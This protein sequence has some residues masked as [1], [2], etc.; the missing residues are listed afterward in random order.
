[1]GDERASKE[2]LLRKI[3]FFSKLEQRDLKRLAKGSVTRRF[4]DGEVIV[5]EGQE[6]L[7]LYFILSGKVHVVR[8]R[9]ERDYVLATLEPEEFFGELSLLDGRPRS[10]DVVALGETECLVLTRSQFSAYGKKS[11]EVAWKILPFLTERLR[12]M[13]ERILRQEELPSPSAPQLLRRGAGEQ[14][15]KGEGALPPVVL[16]SASVQGDQGESLKDQ[17]KGFLLGLFRS[18]A[19]LRLQVH[20]FTAITGCPVAL[21]IYGRD[22]VPPR[23][24]TSFSVGGVEVC[25]VTGDGIYT[26]EVAGTDEGVFDLVLLQTP[27]ENTLHTIVYEDIPTD[28]HSKALIHFDRMTSH[29]GLSLY[30]DGGCSSMGEI[31]P[32]LRVVQPSSVATDSF[33]L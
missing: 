16:S 14:G 6:G 11:P 27:S 19:L 10:A 13:D 22:E 28:R 4:G 26:V 29:Y 24:L 1:M 17:I 12:E 25:S 32:P 7:G 33:D 3:P 2:D 18:C 23:F 31:T 5:R 20:A 15:G 30:K 21:S 9:P 8:K